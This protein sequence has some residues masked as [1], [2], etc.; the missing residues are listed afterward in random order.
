MNGPKSDE[1]G[2]NDPGEY[3]ASPRL[4]AARG[5][6]GIDRFADLGPGTEPK[7]D[8]KEV[9][10]VDPAEIREGGVKPDRLECDGTNEGPLG[11]PGFLLKTRRYAAI[12]DSMRIWL[13]LRAPRACIVCSIII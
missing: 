4:I 6:E 8:P 12:G 5:V 9:E 7:D 1:G 11:V 13:L 2:G 3:E 10:G